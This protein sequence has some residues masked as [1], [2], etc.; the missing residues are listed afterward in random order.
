MTL[1]TSSLPQ[2][3]AWDAKH[4]QSHSIEIIIS[5][6]VFPQPYIYIGFFTNRALLPENGKHATQILGAA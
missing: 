6:T 3:D 1:S 2:P 5:V 4:F